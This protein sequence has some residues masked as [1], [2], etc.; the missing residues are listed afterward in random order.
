MF[1]SHLLREGILLGEKIYGAFSWF[2]TFYPLMEKTR[3]EH[4]GV[5]N[6]IILRQFQSIEIP[7]T[8]VGGGS[9]DDGTFFLQKFTFPRYQKKGVDI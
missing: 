3:P 7:Q 2:I 4:I 5:T 9:V 8:C 1:L 6:S